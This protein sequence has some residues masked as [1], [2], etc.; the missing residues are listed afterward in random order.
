MILGADK[1]TRFHNLESDV[2]DI[3]SI[4]PH[5]D[6]LAQCDLFPAN[7]KLFDIVNEFSDGLANKADLRNYNFSTGK[8]FEQI[9]GIYNWQV[10]NLKSAGK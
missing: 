8:F 10:I 1:W 3:H 5:T 6:I 2:I 9:Q 7:S 4:E